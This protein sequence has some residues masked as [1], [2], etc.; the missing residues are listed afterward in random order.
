MKLFPGGYGGNQGGGWNQGNQGGW[1]QGYG[2]GGSGGYGGGN[3]NQRGNFGGYNQGNNFGGGG[4]GG[5]YSGNG[6]LFS[7]ISIIE[8]KYSQGFK[9]IITSQ[10][11]KIGENHARFLLVNGVATFDLLRL[12]TL[13]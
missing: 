3:F 10:M 13:N 11:C 9:I 2:G 5:D 8:K 7:V 1:N 6:E 12:M 4:G